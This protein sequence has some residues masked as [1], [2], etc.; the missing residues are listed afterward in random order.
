MLMNMHALMLNS[1]IPGQRKAS[2]IIEVGKAF[3]G[4]WRGALETSTLKQYAA[5]AKI[6]SPLPQ[7]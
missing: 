7:Q 2:C 6:D 3:A 1:S 5:T 4:H